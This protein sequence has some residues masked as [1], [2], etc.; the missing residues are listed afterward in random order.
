[1]V[2][3]DCTWHVPTPD[4]THHLSAE[5]VYPPVK[6]ASRYDQPFGRGSPKCLDKQTNRQTNRQTDKLLSQLFPCMKSPGANCI[7]NAKAYAMAV[8][9]LRFWTRCKHLDSYM[10]VAKI[11]ALDTEKKYIFVRFSLATTGN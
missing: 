9:P 6:T 5:T 2:S 1:M 11:V 8:C 4:T 10:L 7:A 3:A